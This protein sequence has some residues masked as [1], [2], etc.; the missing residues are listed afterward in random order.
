MKQN[1]FPAFL[2]RARINKGWSQLRL[3]HQIY[4][5]YG[6]IIDPS[7]ISR[8]ERNEAQPDLTTSSLLAELLGFSLDEAL[9]IEIKADIIATESLI[10]KIASNLARMPKEKLIALDSF[11]SL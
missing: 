6:V 1:S 7:S 5:L 10:M 3:S 9:G 11:L 8:Y 2:K 4:E